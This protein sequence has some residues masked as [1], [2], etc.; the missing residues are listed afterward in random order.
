[1]SSYAYYVKKIRFGEKA[2]LYQKGEWQTGLPANDRMELFVK[3]GSS[4][5]SINVIVENL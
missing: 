5:S 4:V 1:M 3:S 2:N